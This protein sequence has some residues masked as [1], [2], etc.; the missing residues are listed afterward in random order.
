MEG[1]ATCFG[2]MGREGS[3]QVE[4]PSEAVRAKQE[5][6]RNINRRVCG[7]VQSHNLL[8]SPGTSCFERP[9][10]QEVPEDSKA[11]HGPV[12]NSDLPDHSSGHF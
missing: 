3:A 4:K 11:C 7:L 10:K 5:S 12:V 6:V 2:T 8:R 1:H 9:G